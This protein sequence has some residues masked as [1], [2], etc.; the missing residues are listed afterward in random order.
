[1]PSKDI[2]FNAKYIKNTADNRKDNKVQG[3]EIGNG[4]ILAKHIADGAVTAEKIA[5]G[6]VTP[7]KLSS[8]LPAFYAQSAGTN[9]TT[10]AGGILIFNGGVK[11]NIG[12]HYNPSTYR[13]TAPYAGLYYFWV[14]YFNNSTGGPDRIFLAIDGSAINIPYLLAPSRVIGS[15][16]MGGLPVYLNAGNIV[17]IR[18]QY[19][20][21]LYYGDH[22][23]WG[24]YLIR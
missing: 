23:A 6:S 18:A 13:F 3:E 1:M 7:E 9:K 4:T 19:G 16:H 2:R 15:A 12:G 10:V 14:G 17:D 24:G 21:G 20:G 5:N 22:T 11:F 8:D